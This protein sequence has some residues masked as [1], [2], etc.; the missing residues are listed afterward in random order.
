MTSREPAERP[1]Q[2]SVEERLARAQAALEEA[3]EER[4]R[5]WQELHRRAAQD[6]ELAHLRGA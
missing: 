5:L 4:N 2:A 6:E 1:A 3:L